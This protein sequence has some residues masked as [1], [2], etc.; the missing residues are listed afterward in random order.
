[1]GRPVAN[2]DYCRF[3]TTQTQWPHNPKCT[4]F[5]DEEDECALDKC[6]FSEKWRTWFEYLENID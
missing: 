5:D 2:D 4:W 6:F 1:M 3:M